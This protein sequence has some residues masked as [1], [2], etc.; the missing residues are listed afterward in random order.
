MS[1]KQN[2]SL[3]L[4][5]PTWNGS[6]TNLRY[7]VTPLLVLTQGPKHKTNGTSNNGIAIVA[8]TDPKALVSV[9]AINRCK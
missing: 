2:N 1:I 4:R 9:H 6:N 3:V 5:T 8:R 7:C